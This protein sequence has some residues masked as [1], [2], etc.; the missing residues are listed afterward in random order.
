MNQFLIINFAIYHAQISGA[1]FNE[2]RL[3]NLMERPRFEKAGQTSQV[4]LEN[5]QLPHFV[6]YSL[7]RNFKLPGS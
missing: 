1:V 7:F 6:T 4:R 3:A 5:I 2:V